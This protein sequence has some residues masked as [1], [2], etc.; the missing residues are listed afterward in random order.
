MTVS[1]QYTG[2]RQ[3]ANARECARRCTHSSLHSVSWHASLLSSNPLVAVY[4]GIKAVHR[5]ETVSALIPPDLQA[6]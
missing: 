5:I 2:G 1:I 4:A 6:G 3:C